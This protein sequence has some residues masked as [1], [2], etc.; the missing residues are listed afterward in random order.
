MYV[1]EKKNTKVADTSSTALKLEKI[2]IEDTRLIYNDRSV[3]MLID[4]KGF[5]YSGNGD[6]S[7]DIFDLDSHAKIDSL[8][9]MLGNEPYLINKK[10][11]CRVNY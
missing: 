1:S 2:Q 3:D 6:L 8:N 9:F 4:A 7:K 5:D 11:R 10:S